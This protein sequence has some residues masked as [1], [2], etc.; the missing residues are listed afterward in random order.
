MG[1]AQVEVLL[2]L[3]GNQIRKSALALA[4]TALLSPYTTAI[5]YAGCKD[6]SAVLKRGEPIVSTEEKSNGKRWVKAKILIKAS[7]H[8]VWETVHE[9]RQHDPDLAYS[10]ILEQG[11]NEATLEQKFALIPIVGTSVCVMKNYE[12]P[13]QRIDYNMIKSDRFKALEGSWVLTPAEEAGSTYLE[14]SSHLDMGLPIPRQLVENGT[15]KKLQRRLSNVKNM[16]EA[17]QSRLAQNK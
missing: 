15:A 4:L 17:T 13:L 7:P 1:T 3:T 5:S 8:V 9:E 10:K 2:K 11:N 14:L 16:A 6:D 12:V